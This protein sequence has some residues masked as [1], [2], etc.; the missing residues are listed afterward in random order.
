[1]KKNNSCLP[2]FENF[3]GGKVVMKVGPDSIP[4]LVYFTDSFCEIIHSSRDVIMEKTGKSFSDIVFPADRE[5]SE[6]V[7]FQ[8]LSDTKPFTFTCR[9][10]PDPDHPVWINVTCSVVLEDKIKTVY[11]TCTNADAEMQAKEKL[12]LSEQRFRIAADHSD[13]ALWEYHIKEDYNEYSEKAQ[14]RYHFPPVLHHIPAALIEQGFIDGS[15]AADLLKM[16]TEIRRGNKFASCELIYREGRRR[17]KRYALVKMTNIYDEDGYPVSAI[18]TAEDIT[19]KK[20]AL[21]RFE[22]EA[23]QRVSLETGLVSKVYFNMDEDRIIDYDISRFDAIPDRKFK[24]YSDLLSVI[25]MSVPDPIQKECLLRELNIEN[26]RALYEEGTL[27]TGIETVRVLKGRHRIWTRTD[28]HMMKHPAQGCPVV[29]VFTRDITAEKMNQFIIDAVVNRTYDFIDKI[30]I[31]SET[32]KFFSFAIKNAVMPDAEGNYYS[33][34]ILNFLK[35]IIYPDDLKKLLKNRRLDNVE[36]QLEKNE[37]Y[38]FTVRVLSPEGDIYTKKYQYRYL[39]RET[40]TLLLT[41]LDVTEALKEEWKQKDLL[42]TAL[43]SAKQASAAKSNFLSRMSHEIRT[44]MNA[45]IGMAAI[46]DQSVGNDTKISD[47]ISKISLS[48]KYLLSLI[49]DILDMSRIESGRMLLRNEKFLFKEF[50]NGINTIIDNQAVNKGL[51]YKCILSEEVEDCYTGDAMKLQQ[52]LINILGNAVKYTAKGKI[53]FRVDQLSR[54]G[55]LSILRFT[56]TDTGRGISKEFMPKIFDMFEQEDTSSTTV[57]GGTGLGLAI[58]RH[59]AELMG[60]HISVKSVLGSGSEFSVDIPLTVDKGTGSLPEKSCR[61]EQ[62]SA[63]VVDDVTAC[64]QD[65]SF[66]FSG[67]RILVAEDNALNAEIAVSLLENR[68]FEVETVQNGLKALE[69]F[70]SKPSYYYDAVLM[71]VRMPVMDGLQAAAGIRHIDRED[72]KTVPIIAMTANAFDEDVEK[73]RSA[74][75]DAH[76]AKP[77]EPDLLYRE[78]HRLLCKKN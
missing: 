19:E 68:H 50:I 40:G 23:M 41:Q 36:K 14:E 73:S 29:F 6:K 78:L 67:K 60:G 13:L 51:D 57:F 1:M 54:K 63:L 17:I 64:K 74:G 48:A 70:T 15:C 46:A 61:F 4:I 59:L 9:L 56:V 11:C 53:L 55:N 8:G 75:M 3:P 72:A 35:A 58:S 16:Y 27:P 32:Y 38:E 24:T 20:E 52:I 34:N 77:V 76:L 12:G 69:I 39:D 62:M 44:P 30:D 31:P 65:P 10:I 49:N 18:G 42:E 45:I 21:I 25:L 33:E 5:N 2:D 66:D 43:I 47:C 37:L 28:V 26:L 71:D 7:F 22:D